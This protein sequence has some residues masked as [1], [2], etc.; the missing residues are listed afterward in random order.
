[1]HALPRRH[2]KGGEAHAEPALGQAA[3][4]GIDASDERRFHLRLGPSGDEPGEDGAEAFPGGCVV[5]SCMTARASFDRLRMRNSVRGS[6]CGLRR[7]VLILSLSKD[8]RWHCSPE[9]RPTP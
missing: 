7:K 8:A 5:M 2:G 1:M 6:I 9:A 3:H 4:R